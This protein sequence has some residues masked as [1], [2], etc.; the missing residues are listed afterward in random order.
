MRTLVVRPLLAGIAL[1]LAGVATVIGGLLLTLSEQRAP[2]AAPASIFRNVE[3]V[4]VSS[5][6]AAINFD[7]Q[8]APGSNYGSIRFAARPTQCTDIWNRLS[9]APS[10]ASS[11]QSGSM[12]GSNALR[13]VLAQPGTCR[14]D[15]VEIFVVRESDKQQVYQELAALPLRLA[16]A[17]AVAAVPATALP[18]APSPTAVPASATAAAP[19]V[20]ATS[21][22]E[23]T[24]TVPASATATAQ[25]SKTA[26][27]VPTKTATAVPTK[28]ATA[29]PTKTA[30]PTKKAGSTATVRAATQ[31]S[32]VLAA[33]AATSATPAATATACVHPP[34]WV[35]H[36]IQSSDFLIMLAERSNISVKELQ[37]ANCIVTEK[38]Y[39]GFTIYLPPTASPT[40]AAAP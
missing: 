28:A 13:I 15:T 34:T 19:T 39:L 1:G 40:K 23:P 3:I 38:I 16:L 26:T 29:A 11:A 37:R 30:Q 36:T 33:A 17:A 9:F 20:A 5:S 25:A 12:R 18:P 2:V 32:A 24:A 10:A 7:F 14:S 21:S 22:P 8:L 6:E 35:P 27:V 4:A 31:T